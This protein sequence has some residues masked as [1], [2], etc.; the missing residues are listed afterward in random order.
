MEAS[1]RDL[2]IVGARAHAREVYD[3]AVECNR[4]SPRWN[5]VGFVAH[6][7]SQTERV[8]RHG[9]PILDGLG[10]LQAFSRDT[11]EYLIGL[12]SPLERR[13][14]DVCDCIV[15]DYSSINPGGHLGGAV[16]LGVGVSVG[17]GAVF[18]PGV[19]VG[20]WSVIGA[21][22]AVVRDIEAGVTAI[23]VPARPLRR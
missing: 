1:M 11:T 23:G 13:E 19:T 7:E 8:A 6:G 18:K 2:V 16:R 20:D 12:G 14:V 15:G 9:L 4:A 17:L 10:A 3:A 5:F 22:A 21:G